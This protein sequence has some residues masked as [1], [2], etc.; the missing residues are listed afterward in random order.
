MKKEIT[1]S[2]LIFLFS[3]ADFLA[4]IPI[5]GF[6]KLTEIQV[7]SNYTSFAAIDYNFDGYRDL[8]LFNPAQKNY[9]TITAVSRTSYNKPSEKYSSFYLS[10]IESYS[11]DK[12]SKKYLAVSRKTNEAGILSFSKGGSFTV[13]AKLKLDGSPAAQDEWKT[14]DGAARNV[15]FAGTGLDGLVLAKLNNGKPR[16]TDRIKGKIFSSAVFLDLNY[17]GY[18]DIAAIDLISNSIVFYNNDALGNFEEIRSIGLVSE[19]RDFQAVEFNSDKFT[20]LVFIKQNKLEILLGDSVSTFQTKIV[21]DPEQG[22]EKYSIMDFNGDGYNDVAFIDSKKSKLYI[23]FAKSYNSFYEPIA[24]VTRNNLSDVVSYVDRGGRKLAALSSDG[25]VFVVSSLSINDDSFSLAATEKAVSVQ[26]FD[27]NNDKY[28]ELAFIDAGSNTL[29]IGLSERRNLFRTFF[30]LPLSTTPDR[31]VIDDSKQNSTLFICYK[32]GSREIEVIRYSFDKN[33][34]HKQI[35]YADAPIKEVKYVT[36]RL[37]DRVRICALTLKNKLLSLQEFELRNFKNPVID[38]W[39]VA[40]NVENASFNFNVYKDVYALIRLGNNVDLVK[41]VFDKGEIE[42]T[43]RLSFQLSGE[44]NIESQIVTLNEF[45]FR[46]KP[47]AAI[48]T[49]NKRYVLY[50]FWNEKNTRMDLTEKPGLN[51]PLKYYIDGESVYFLCASEKDDKILEITPDTKN[52]K[53]IAR[54]VEKNIIDYF[55]TALYGKNKFL[56]YI[57]GKNNIITFNKYL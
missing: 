27:Y 17:D 49:F 30:S 46:T 3:S 31:L 15:L 36:D 48:L 23:M 26:A 45:V 25:S 18:E 37:K 14:E 24:Y 22:I 7:K 53:T 33:S 1:L 11:I 9:C 6:C 47:A 20:D 21:I 29:K 42:R 35:L 12:S 57:G 4:Q 50:Y 55:V 43:P 38:K 19:I 10:A 44:E 2:V 52:A 28:K 8:I 41:I 51:T 16:E 40:H 32:A 56:V 39:V 34:I 54:V 13:S 5:N